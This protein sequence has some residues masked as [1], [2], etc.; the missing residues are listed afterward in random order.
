MLSFWG[1]HGLINHITFS[2]AASGC[3]QLHAVLWRVFRRGWVGVGGMGRE[4]HTYHCLGGLYALY[5]CPVYDRHTIYRVAT[6]LKESDFEGGRGD[7]F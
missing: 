5:G 3:R 7:S 6:P 2:V 1:D 4:T